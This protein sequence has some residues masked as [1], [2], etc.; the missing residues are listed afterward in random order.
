MRRVPRSSSVLAVAAALLASTVVSSVAAPALAELAAKDV[1][2]VMAQKRLHIRKVC[3]AD[4]ADK[5]DTSVKVDF[6]VAPNGVVTDA[7]ARDATGPQAIVDCI[8]AEVKKTTFPA[9]ETGGRF[10]WPFIFK[11]P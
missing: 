1:V 2:S 4:R 5:A 6:G 10:R 3:Y 9:S 7:T 8:V 11:G